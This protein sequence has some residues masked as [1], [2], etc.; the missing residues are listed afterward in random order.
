MKLE[1]FF[2]IHPMVDREAVEIAALHLEGEA[3]TWWFGHWSHARVSTPADF[4]QRLSR[5]FGQRREETSP[6][7]E[8]AHASIVTFVEE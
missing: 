7:V 5:R 4:S 6:L 2:L 8:E 1:A 3:K